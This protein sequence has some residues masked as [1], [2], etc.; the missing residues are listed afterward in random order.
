MV[1]EGDTVDAGG[2]AC[3]PVVRLRIGEVAEANS[4][5]V[6]PVSVTDERRTTK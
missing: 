2:A 4:V 3:V 6:L 5:V 1:K